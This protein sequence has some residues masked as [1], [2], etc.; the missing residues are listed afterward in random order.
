M[1][2]T[3]LRNS[4]A[5]AAGFRL[6]AML[7]AL[8][9]IL[10]TIGVFA[11]QVFHTALLYYTVQSNILALL[12]F[13]V[14]FVR[15]LRSPKGSN[16][17]FSPRLSFLVTHAIMITMFVFW[18]VLAPFDFV[19]IAYLL[20]L[21]NLAVHLITPLLVL[22]DYLFFHKRGT[23][24]KQDCVLCLVYPYIYLAIVL[25]LGLLHKV[26]FGAMWGSPSYYPYMFLDID[27][28]GWLVL[29]IVLGMSGF[30]AL[31][32]WLWYRADKKLGNKNNL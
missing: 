23:L 26:N 4:K 12:L 24:K 5:F 21:D 14:Y 15:T 25:P 10:Q 29:P 32:A 16:Y 3:E 7:F 2:R 11:G 27:L 18:F 19:P 22:F 9:G 8:W 17:G 28:L 30:F 20:R 6:F 1:K 31:L 13:G